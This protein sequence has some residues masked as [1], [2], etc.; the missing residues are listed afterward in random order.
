MDAANE[1]AAPAANHAITNFSA[2][3]SGEEV[4]FEK[5]AILAQASKLGKSAELS[6]GSL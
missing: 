5:A 6:F 4:G 3:V 2:H 1:S